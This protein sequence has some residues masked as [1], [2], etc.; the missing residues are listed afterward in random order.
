MPRYYFNV[1][2]DGAETT[3]VVGETCADDVEALAHAL[4]TAGGWLHRSAFTH[5]S[6]HDGWIAVEDEKHREVMKLP[7][8]AAAY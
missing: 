3:D 6:V 4:R 8:M 1:L 7:L 5:H 2:C